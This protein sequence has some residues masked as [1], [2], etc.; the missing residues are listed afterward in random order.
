[1]VPCPPVVVNAPGRTRTSDQQLRR[2]LLYPPELRAQVPALLYFPAP[3]DFVAFRV[4]QGSL[5]T[6]ASAGV[7]ANVSIPNIRFSAAASA[8]RNASASY[9]SYRSP[10][11]RVP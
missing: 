2:L 10:M 5:A 7:I 4:C 9:R 3:T 6:I 11:S 8:V 1:M